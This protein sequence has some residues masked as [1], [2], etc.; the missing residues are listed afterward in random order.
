MVEGFECHPAR[1]AAVAD[2]RNGAVGAAFEAVAHRQSQGG[3]NGSGGMAGTKSVV[4][5]FR[6]LGKTADAVELAQRMELGTASRE[7]LVG[8]G[9]M[10]DVPDNLVVRG[11]EN[12]MEGDGQLDDS[13]ARRQVTAVLC[14]GANDQVADFPGQLLQLA[15]SELLQLGR[16]LQLRNQGL[17]VLVVQRCHAP[18]RRWLLLCTITICGS[19]DSGQWRATVRPCHQMRPVPPLPAQPAWLQLPESEQAP[20]A[21]GRFSCSWRRPTPKPCP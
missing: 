3:G 7:D 18:H 8:V 16:T 10:P 15:G 19:A 20:G 14:Y 9:L 13:Q 2:D 6:A 1:H 21:P 11:V 17:V 5:A 4:L 12:V